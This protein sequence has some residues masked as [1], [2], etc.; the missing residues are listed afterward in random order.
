MFRFAFLVFLI[1]GFE[2]IAV[3]SW[4]A[5]TPPNWQVTPGVLCTP[6]DPNFEG[7]YYSEHIARCNRAVG[8][9][10]KEQIAQEYG[11]IPKADWPQYEFDHLIP[12][13]AGGSD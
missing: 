8:E 3:S 2:C 7:Y 1:S 4:A 9:Q 6:Q 5:I 11:N 13:C 10:E 12:L